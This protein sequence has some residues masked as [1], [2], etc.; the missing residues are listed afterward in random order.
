MRSRTPATP[1]PG[2]ALNPHPSPLHACVHAQLNTQTG[3]MLYLGQPQARARALMRA[4]LAGQVLVTGEA[5]RAIRE[6]S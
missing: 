4:A 5:A 2:G 6:G 1:M 3:K